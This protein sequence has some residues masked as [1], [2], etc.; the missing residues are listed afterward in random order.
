MCV[1]RWKTG[2]GPAELT[3]KRRSNARE[4][5]MMALLGVFS[6]SFLNYKFKLQTVDYVLHII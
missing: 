1:P 2:G 4:K 3:L 5:M 6:H